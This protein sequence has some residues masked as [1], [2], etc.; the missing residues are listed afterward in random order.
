MKN[1]GINLKLY[2]ILDVNINR[3]VEGLRVVEEVSRFILEDRGLTSELKKIRGE[4]CKIIRLSDY[5][6][7]ALRASAGRQKERIRGTED[8][9]SERKTEKLLKSRRAMEDVGRSLYTE[10]E[11]RRA[12]IKDVFQANIK[13]AQEAVRC[14]EEFSKLIDPKSGK[15]FKDIRFKLY[16]LEKNIALRIKRYNLLDFDL[17]VVTDPMR[18]H[19]ETANQAIAGGVKIIQ[20][21]DKKAAKKQFS[22][23]AEKISKMAKKA[24]AAFIVNDYL[25]IAKQVGAE[26]VHLGQEDMPIRKARKLLGGDKIIG[27]S[28]H[29]FVQALKAEKDGAD[30]ISVG[31]VFSTPSKPGVKPVGLRLLQKI[32][33]QVKVP[34]VAIG[35]INDSNI[36]R[37]NRA[38]CQRAAVIRA[39]L[40]KKNMLKAL[41]RLRKETY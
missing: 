8:Q 24:G 3:A 6:A 25:D 41:K 13:R 9:I 10:G 26:G 11:G 31:P 14:L 16:E 22:K 5:P 27:V 33:N 38:G 34:V 28:T 7:F 1:E 12:S 4:V 2:R 36:G 37:V 40:G 29:S 20:L 32:V 18:D 35:G 23:W 30:Y 19:V 15:R 39:V 17:Y 21:R